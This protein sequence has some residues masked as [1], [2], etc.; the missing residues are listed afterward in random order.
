MVVETLV[1]VELDATGIPCPMPLLKLKQHLNKMEVGQ[2][3]RIKTTDSGS[4]RDFGVFVVQAGHIM[5]EKADNKGE[6]VFV[7]EKG[8]AS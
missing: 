4:V 7:I 6:F 1:D 5:V 2:K 3:I 8:P